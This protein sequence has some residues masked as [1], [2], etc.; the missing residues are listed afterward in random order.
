[1]TTEQH[2][3]QTTGTKLNFHQIEF[4]RWM[5]ICSERGIPYGWM[6]QVVTMEWKDKEGGPLAKSN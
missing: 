6:E 5:R 2:M 3:E 1:M 4:I